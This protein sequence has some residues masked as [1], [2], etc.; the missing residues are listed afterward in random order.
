MAKASQV[1]SRRKLLNP[2][3]HLQT[4]ME[5]DTQLTKGMIK[6]VR[7]TGQLN[8]SGRG[9]GTVPST[10]FTMY[11]DDE[12]IVSYDLGKSPDD[13]WW[14]FKPLN[15]LD[16]SSNTLQEIPIDI[17]M[18]EDLTVLNLQDNC[19]ITLPKEV[20]ML[21]KLTKINLSHNKITNLP[22]ECFNFPDLVQFNVSYNNLEE[23]SAEIGN[24]VMLQQLDLSHNNLTTLPLGL[25]Y[26]VRLNDINLSH[27]K[28]TELPPDI[29]SLR[30]LIKLD[31]THNNLKKLP[32]A[33]GELRKMQMLH[34]QHND[35]DDLPNFEGCEHIQE[36]HM[37]N[38][39]IDCVRK[40]FCEDVAN[41]KILDLRDNKI[42]ELPKEIA[43]LQHLIRLDLTNNDLTSLPNTLGLL[44]HL[45]N[46]QVEGNVLKNIRQD[47][48][49]GGTSRILKHLRDKLN[50]ED[51]KVSP[52]HAFKPLPVETSEFPNK[53]VMRN[54]RS[55][56]LGMKDLTSIP[57][58]VFEDALAAEVTIVDLCKNKL[59]VV[60]EGLKLVSQNVSELNL[61]VN[62]L[63][64]VPDFLCDFVR[65][66]FIDFSR[67]CLTE[68]PERFSILK[69][70]RELILSNNRFT[71]VPN[72]I[73]ALQNL[74]ILLISDNQ[75]TNINVDGLKQLQRLA[76]LDLSN[77]D[78]GTVPPELGNMKQL[79]HLELK[80][81]RFRQPRYAILEQGTDS[82]LAYLRD[83]IR[84]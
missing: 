28:L 38:N 27:N 1:K 80:G 68:L 58:T 60:P 32:N 20:G 29:V 4:K 12:N 84:K 74:E 66:Q 33:M 15:Y 22:D 64:T 57:D 79:R 43:M 77:N 71:S 45:Q 55:L 11:N 17:K 48:I 50:E 10:M 73:Y 40:E 54:S 70:M 23:V 14:S 18:F 30:A 31:V 37:G 42:K 9:M 19:L 24:L 59:A 81:N 35:I 36:I 67:N 25:G 39:F 7:R 34:A 41:L 8:L 76:T 63:K 46:L 52:S 56:N 13:A 5:D 65:L 51:M 47:I 6:V 21:K 44:P 75:V 16:L 3:F 72:C 61:S 49:K 2:V 53:Y 62:V 83:R 78:I 26:L 69:N 82:I